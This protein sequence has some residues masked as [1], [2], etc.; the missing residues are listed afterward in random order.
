MPRRLPLRDAA[1]RLRRLAQHPATRTIAAISGVLMGASLVLVAAAV[2]HCSFA[3]GRCPAPAVPWWED[4]AFGTVAVGLAV[5]WAAPVLAW[6]PSRRGLR[7]AAVGVVAALPLA[8]LFA[9]ALRT[10]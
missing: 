7:L 4:D 3:G 6:R 8:W 2:G 1:R 9:E 5:L 10:G